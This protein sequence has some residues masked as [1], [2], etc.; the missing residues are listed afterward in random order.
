LTASFVYAGLL[1]DLNILNLSP[2]LESLV[3]SSFVKLEKSA[4]VVPF[5][6]AGES[7]LQLFALVDGIYPP[8]SRFVKGIQLSVTDSEKSFT[9]W[10][11]SARKD[12]EQAFGVLQARFQ[13]M[14]RPFHRHS[15]RKLGKIVSECLIMHSMC[16]SDS[17]MSGNAY[18][19][20]N[21]CYNVDDDNEEDRILE[22]DRICIEENNN[23]DDDKLG[24]PG[25]HG[26][27]QIGLANT[28]NEFVQQHMLA[29]Q[30]R[31]RGLNDR[32]EQACLHSA[33]I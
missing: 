11:E 4:N 27:A 29:C 22:E 15:L 10:Q 32:N 12:I 6:V 23:H 21:P 28:D 5:Q 3:D 17:V 26:R 8:Y 31:R 33:L 14:S 1:N 19:V 2:F 30:T 24:P 16:I 7:F 25:R 18:A 9:V 13:V 20:Y